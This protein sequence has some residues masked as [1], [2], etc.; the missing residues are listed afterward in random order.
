[1]K[2][3]ILTSVAGAILLIMWFIMQGD[4]AAHALVGMIGAFSVARGVSR[5]IARR[6]DG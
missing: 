5:I 2:I 6:R 1:M 4:T 3:D